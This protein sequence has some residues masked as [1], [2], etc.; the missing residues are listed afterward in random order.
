M[1]GPLTPFSVYSGSYGRTIIFTSTKKEAN[2]LGLS[3]LMQSE[4]QALHGDIPQT[5]RERTLEKFREGKVKCLIATDVAAR[6]IDIPEVDLVIQCEPPEKSEDYVH[7]SGRT[8]RAGRSG[9]CILFYKPQQEYLVKN[10]EQR[11][12]VVFKRVGAPQPIDI[13]QASSRDALRALGEVPASV[14]PMFRESAQRLIDERGDAVEVLSAALAIISGHKEEIQARSLL[15]SLANFT[16]YIMTLDAE[17]R[18]N[19]YVYAILE[20]SLGAELKSE[21]RGMRLKAD[22]RAAVFDVPSKYDS[23]IKEN[24][25]D[26]RG[27]LLEVA[28]E[29]PELEER[30][31]GGSG[32]GYGGGNG[33]YG[34]G[35]YNRGGR[36]GYGGGQGGYGNHQR[37]Y[38]SGRGI[39]RGGFGRGRGG[40][41]R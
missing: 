18:T 1:G 6:G 8:G 17:V 11:T 12:G 7:R 32:G 13:V 21:V 22:H 28:T 38:S 3:S 30:A 10:I 24:W 37:G 9:V 2:E 39:G 15:S 31:E 23:F 33:G 27:A 36:G 25:A 16:T 26:Q 40:H 20:R 4:C 35:G 14:L 5:Q 41:G 19:A 34:G 29:L